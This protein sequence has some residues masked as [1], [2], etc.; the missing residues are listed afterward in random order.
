MPDD[1]A[2]RSAVLSQ[3]SLPQNASQLHGRIDDAIRL[4]IA[5][6]LKVLDNR[7]L[8]D[9]FR[10]RTNP[11]A[12]GE[13]WGKTIRSACPLYVYTGDRELYAI[14]ARSVDDLLS[15]QTPDGCISTRT[16]DEQPKSSDL[17]ERKYVLLGLQAWYAISS[18]KRALIAM[19]LMADYTLNQ[20]GPAPRTR[21]VDTGWA[22]EGIESSS[23]LEPIM[24][25]YRLTGHQR[26]LDFARY[27]VEDEGACKRGSIFEAALNGVL[28]KDI[29]SNG[30][31]K[32]SIA[33]AYESMSCFE[34]LL[35]Y[36]RTT[37]IA[38]WRDSALRYYKSL[39]EHEI[40]IIG[41]GGGEGAYNCG[42]GTG[43]QWNHLAH[44]QS[45]PTPRLLM[46][47]C[48]TV[49][50][51]KF[52]LQVLRTSG[53][54][55]VVDQIE[56]SL[57]NALLGAL[58]PSGDC[59]DYFQNFNGTRNA[60]VN[61][62]SDISEFSLSCCTA[63]GPMGLAVIPAVAVMVTDAG[64]AINL[65]LPG[66]YTIAQTDGS[67]VRLEIATQ[68]PHDGQISVTVTPATA[69]RLAIAVRIPAWSNQT[70]LVVHGDSSSVTPGTYAVIDRTWSPGDRIELSLDLRCRQFLAPRGSDRA[71]DNFQALI[72]GPLVLARDKRLG[73]DIDAP[74]TFRCD[75]GGCIATTAQA[76]PPGIQICLDAATTGAPCPLIDYAS[77]GS[78]WD[79]RS[80]FRTW[81][82]LQR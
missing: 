29:G 64:M 28:P 32:Q 49:T 80:R 10:H 66:S 8:V 81:M 72:R 79:E 59:W 24:V 53:N 5:R 58:R 36:Y 46:E 54:P 27:I 35:E 31:P 40:T 22:F 37:N 34:G 71:G 38:R 25:L 41:S 50:W 73:G 48:V 17:W 76:S 78:T 4:S 20:I 55:T 63:N 43:E 42:P 9:Y 68:Y 52:C 13:F 2:S 69:R 67:A 45:S 21:I 18:D 11:F 39:I 74:I 61:F 75:H 70:T 82:P 6:H 33:K 47:T 56:L 7:K 1:I 23:I 77:A 15:T 26:Y 65:F 30:D 12:A 19:E 60:K 3:R 44:D 51:M 16:Y 62:A 57:Y 14:I